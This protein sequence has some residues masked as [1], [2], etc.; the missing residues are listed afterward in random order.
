VVEGNW[1][2]ASLRR[3]AL[4]DD[5]GFRV[6]FG[7]KAAELARTAAAAAAPLPPPPRPEVAS[8]GRRGWSRR[9]KRARPAEDPGTDQEGDDDDDDGDSGA[10]TEDGSVTAMPIRLPPAEAD[11]ALPDRGG[12]SPPPPEEVRAAPTTA[13]EQIVPNAAA[14]T[15]TTATASNAAQVMALYPRSLYSDDDDDHEDDHDD[16]DGREDNG[17]TSDMEGADGAPLVSLDAAAL[18]QVEVCIRALVCALA[19]SRLTPL[20]RKPTRAGCA[21]AL[22]ARSRAP[23]ACP[24]STRIS[25]TLALRK[26]S[27][28]GLTCA[29]VCSLPWLARSKLEELLTYY[30]HQRD[31]WR[32]KSYAQAIAALRRHPRRVTSRAEAEQVYGIGKSLADKVCGPSPAGTHLPSLCH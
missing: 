7:A 22:S 3:G 23:V 15:T 24:T 19:A 28:R 25:R 21:A 17:G 12:A 6:P 26:Q 16:D 4:A 10:A 29:C 18:A 32:Q 20:C 8:G 31:P 30:T 5:A 1:V 13:W 27:P 2:S 11:V 14:A 9:H